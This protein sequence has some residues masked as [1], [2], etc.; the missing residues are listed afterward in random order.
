MNSGICG[1][2]FLKKRLLIQKTYHWQ[3][4]LQMFWQPSSSL[5]TH[6]NTKELLFFNHLLLIF[7]PAARTFLISDRYSIYS[8]LFSPMSS[9][10]FVT[11]T[12]TITE[13]SS[14]STEYV[15]WIRQFTGSSVATTTASLC[16]GSTVYLVALRY[17]L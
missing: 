3:S 13:L 10:A 2:E 11:G 15:L 14:I 1:H 7:Q 4:S 9:L 12:S 6:G 8:A 16:P 17:T 5:R